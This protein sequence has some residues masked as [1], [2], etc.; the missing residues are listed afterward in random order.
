MS[1]LVVVHFLF[2]MYAA[3]TLGKILAD[4]VTKFKA[5]S[6]DSLG[7]DSFNQK[8]IEAENQ[9]EEALYFDDRYSKHLLEE[10]DIKFLRSLRRQ[11]GVS[12]KD[13]MWSIW[14]VLPKDSHGFTWVK[15]ERYLKTLFKESGYFNDTKYDVEIAR[16][17]S[18]LEIPPLSPHPIQE[19]NCVG[20]RLFYEY[21][22]EA[23][24]EEKPCM[25]LEKCEHFFYSNGLSTRKLFIQE[26]MERL[27]A[28]K[29]NEDYT[30]ESFLLSRKT[31]TEDADVDLPVQV[32]IPV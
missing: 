2:L 9:F 6:R 14:T 4:I 21:F 7:T 13:R 11:L 10:W 26:E 24:R 25:D 3:Y 19:G 20:T 22:F 12:A 5:Y 8:L 29:T 17:L 23:L 15:V 30:E 32:S 27:I 1:V 18:N 28:M 16:I 31:M